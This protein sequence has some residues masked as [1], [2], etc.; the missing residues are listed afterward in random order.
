[1]QHKAT[2]TQGSIFGHITT[3]STT[4][5]IGFFLRSLSL[6]L[7]MFSSSR[8]SVSPRWPRPLA[9]QLCANPILTALHHPGLGTISNFARDL[10]LA[11][12]LMTVCAAYFGALGVLT[13]QAIANAI[14]GIATFSVALWL[15]HKIE[16]GW[17]LDWPLLS[18]NCHPE[19][20]IPSGVQHR[21]I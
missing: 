10:L 13:G 1:M 16:N 4:W 8:C 9:L 11:I 12:P 14:A 21:G 20:A 5:A 15:S 18:T 17:G 19:R 7:L 3:L 6:I 2:Y